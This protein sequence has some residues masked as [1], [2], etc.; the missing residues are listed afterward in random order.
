MLLCFLQTLEAMDN[1]KPYAAALGDVAAT[2]KWL[3]YYAGAADKLC[4]ETIPIGKHHVRAAYNA[5]ARLV[6]LKL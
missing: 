6:I 2:V 1:G 5:Q 3:R 4:G